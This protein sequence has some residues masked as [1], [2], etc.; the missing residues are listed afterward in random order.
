MQSLKQYAPQI[1]SGDDP[2][3]LED[4]RHYIY[5]WLAE[6]VQAKRLPADQVTA[7]TQVLLEKSEGAFLYL[8]QARDEWEQSVQDGSN[9]FDLSNPATLPSGLNA[10]YLKSFKRRFPEATSDPDNP[11]TRWNAVAKPLLGYI[12]ASREPLPLDLARELMGWEADSAG[13]EKQH[14]A[15]QS[16]G[17]L[18]KRNGD[19]A[20]PETCTLATTS[21]VCHAMP[22]KLAA[23]AEP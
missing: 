10:L 19:A 15:L 6:E 7:I 18:V 13:N 22:H 5:A 12:L 2:A 14:K 21:I 11:A 16:L 9:N 1:I 4:L 17:S 20:K 3:N 8:A 23:F